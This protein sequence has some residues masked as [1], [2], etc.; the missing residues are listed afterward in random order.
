MII[1]SVAMQK[2]VDKLKVLVWNIAAAVKIHSTSVAD[3]AETEAES[4]DVENYAD[5]TPSTDS[6]YSYH[7]CLYLLLPPCSLYFCICPSVCPFVC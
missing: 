6:T 1:C 4:S 2:V 5:S 3:A 7:C